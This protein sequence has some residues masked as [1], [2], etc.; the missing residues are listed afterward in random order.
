MSDKFPK[1]PTERNNRHGGDT[2]STLDVVFIPRVPHP[3]FYPI[4]TTHTVELV[5]RVYSNVDIRR[6]G[7]HLRWILSRQSL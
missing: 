3:G 7:T 5:H 6:D 2:T 4:I 1:S